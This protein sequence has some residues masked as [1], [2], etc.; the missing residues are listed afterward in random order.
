MHQSFMI[1][2]HDVC[3]TLNTRNQKDVIKRLK[4]N[5]AKFHEDL[6]MLKLTWFKKIIKSEKIHLSLIVKIIHKQSDDE[7]TV[8]HEHI[9]LVLKVLLQA[10]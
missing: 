3:I 9:K 1:L 5:N 4:M 8:E 7:L 2:T 6:K 10:V